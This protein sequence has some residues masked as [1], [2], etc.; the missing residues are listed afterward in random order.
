[1][2]DTRNQYLK[3]KDEIDNAIQEVINSSQF[4]QG[5]VVAEF[6]SEVAR[7]LGVK[8]AIGC[9]S[10]TDALQIA[11]MALDIKPGDEVITTP[12]TFVATTE[13]IALLGAKPVYVDIDEKTYNIDVD[14]IE[15]K[16]NPKTKAI[17]PVHLYGL[18]SDMDKIM[19]IAKAYKLFV[20]EDAAQ[21]IG[22]VYKNQKVCT[23]G[24]IGCLSFYPSKNLGAFGDAGMVT[25]NNEELAL[26]IK[27]IISHGS[28]NKY[29][30]E[31]LGVN[32]RLDSIQAAIL[33]VKLKYL[34]QYSNS[35][36][37]AAK[38]YNERF[39][40]KIDP[41]YVLP[42]VKHIFHQYSVRVPGRD[43]LQ[44][45]LKSH[46]VPSMVYYPVPLHLQQ[47]YRYDY[48]AGDFPVSEKVARDIISL[49]MH[50]ELTD[51]HINFISD[52]VL[53]FI[54]NN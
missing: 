40:G 7:Y 35:R 24:D 26:K 47:A 33:K 11:M 8:Y 37:E 52:K 50:T 51:E 19:E 30:H 4:I 22:A 31:I 25:T 21:A 23:I 5:P 38:K 9:A 3:I 53:E 14:K 44:D 39:N 48:K 2:V 1:M 12:F 46:G 13:T 6:E 34:E 16:I 32:S 17:I 43:K 27:M 18:P 45:F 42:Y 10:G 28:K 49:P 29:Y 41:P 36:I 54:K 20:I 15:K